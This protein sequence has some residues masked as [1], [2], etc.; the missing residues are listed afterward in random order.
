MAK[1]SVTAV[2]SGAGIQAGALPNE[3]KFGSINE[4][5]H[6]VKMDNFIWVFNDEVKNSTSF[7]W[8]NEWRDWMSIGAL[9][10]NLNGYYSDIMLFKQFDVVIHFDRSSPTRLIQ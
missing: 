4:L 7:S 2:R 1:G 8:F 9:H 3:V 10:P 5:F 6:L